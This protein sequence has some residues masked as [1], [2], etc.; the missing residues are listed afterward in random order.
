MKLSYA[1]LNHIIFLLNFYIRKS[2]DFSLL[3]VVIPYVDLNQWC[4]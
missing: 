2:K 1:C 3:V 4:N